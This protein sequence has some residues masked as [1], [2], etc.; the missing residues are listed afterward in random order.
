MGNKLHL[1]VCLLCLLIT[2]CIANPH[3]GSGS[4]SDVESEIVSSAVVKSKTCET[5]SLCILYLH[6]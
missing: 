3:S 6:P 5:T 1:L 2:K 4:G